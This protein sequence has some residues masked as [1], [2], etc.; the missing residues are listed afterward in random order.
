MAP[1]EH[2]ARPMSSAELSAAR[3]HVVTVELPSGHRQVIY[4]RDLNEIA[5]AEVLG[6]KVLDSRTDE[7]CGNF[8][9]WVQHRKELPGEA[10]FGSAKPV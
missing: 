3:M 9:G 1:L 10:I 8:N 6:A 2:A 4:T 7:F 5:L